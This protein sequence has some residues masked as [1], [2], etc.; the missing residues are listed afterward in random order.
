MSK[1]IKR[2][3]DGLPDRCSVCER[4]FT[5]IVRAPAVT[6]PNLFGGLDYIC[7]SCWEHSMGSAGIDGPVK[8]T[9]H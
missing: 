3:N 2:N 1:R 9:L 5:K 8:H 6:H 4:K 7:T